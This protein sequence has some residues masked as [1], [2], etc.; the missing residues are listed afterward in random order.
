ML[1][2]DPDNKTPQRRYI[3]IP[4]YLAVSVVLLICGM[5]AAGGL[6]LSST[7]NLTKSPQ[8]AVTAWAIGAGWNETTSG[9]LRTSLLK[10]PIRY[11]RSTGVDPDLPTLVIDIKFR[12]QEHLRVKRDIALERG[13]LI[14]ED[15]DF[16][17]A[18]IRIG[19]RQVPVK[20]RLKGDLP[21]HYNTDKWSMRIEVKGDDHVLGMRRFSL[22]H[23]KVRAFQAEPIFM[24][25][26]RHS[27]V[28]AVRYQFVHVIIN[29]ESKGIMA[30]EEHFS[31]ELVEHQ[32]RRE[33]VFLRFDE[34]NFFDYLNVGGNFRSSPY[35]NYRNSHIKTFATK[36]LANSPSL[37]AQYQTA[38]GLM[39]SFASDQITA[40]EIFDVDSTTSYLAVLELWGSWHGI[41]WNDI[42]F[43]FDP[44]TMK[45]EPI[46]YDANPILHSDVKAITLKREPIFVALLQDPS[47]R[48]EYLKKLRN[49]CQD[50]IDGDLG[51]ELVATEQEL[52]ST[53]R[54]E[55]LL[56][57]PM[58]L[59]KLVE[60]A[61]FLL[62]LDDI[63]LLRN[64]ETYPRR[65]RYPALLQANFI[66]SQNGR[67]IEMANLLPEPVI[68]TS[69]QWRNLE[70]L[71]S[72]PANTVEDYE[73]PFELPPAIAGDAPEFAKL[74]LA[75]RSEASG[76]ELVIKAKYARWPHER[77]IRPLSYFP[78][79]T[80]NPVPNSSIEEQL[81]RHPFLKL[82]EAANVVTIMPGHWTVDSDIIVPAGFTILAEPGTLLEFAPD[83]ALISYGELHF[84][85][86]ENNPVILRGIGSAYWPGIAVLRAGGKSVLRQ[87]EFENTRGITR[88]AWQLTGGVTFY[89]SDVDLEDVSIRQHDGEDALNIV[90]S[91]FDILRLAVSDTLF[92]A[93][94]A[95][96]TTGEIR[97]SVFTN[98]GRNSG[99][100][101]AI[102]FSG[103]QV[104][105]EDVKFQRVADK[106]LSVG[107]GSRA[108]ASNL[109][110][111]RV[112]TAAASKD[113]S[114]LDIDGLVIDEVTFAGLMAYIKKPEYG[115]ASIRAENVRYK[116]T[117]PV[118]RVQTGSLIEVDGTTLPTE[119]LDV[120][121]LYETVM[122]KGF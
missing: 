117:G 5:L 49:L 45:L 71:V 14:Q 101:D 8:S 34:S 72:T 40:S 59:N 68:V 53:L 87:V 103:S 96:F 2:K 74:Y 26:L 113:G 33:G 46:G 88:D 3:T 58:N 21:D 85:G 83:A 73:F 108:S 80:A 17:P 25:T 119:D 60:R 18:T 12:H 70:T 82:A 31:K 107:E 7:D 19:Q 27:G 94:D 98:I 75:D 13:L 48:N 121:L 30:L 24:E 36:K 100:G 89:H 91:K 116:P 55:F 57:E 22:Q 92:D 11:A 106:A 47:I 102:D 77:E 51:T 84:L 104:E 20:L 42:R 43:Y 23:P 99:G 10:I 65:I 66:N 111:N 62:E 120:D 28:L 90:R 63:D 95:D 114:H 41:Q 78:N 44:L 35:D 93:F 118:G 39:R 86:A 112:G 4:F 50:V 122:G 69:I 6:V 81:L 16:V 32:A 56:L 110:M 79:I 9:R 64:P 15:G 76:N 67:Y 115:P 29:G 97:D 105:I 37:S 54:H 38:V 109:T 52:L 1:T 61:Q